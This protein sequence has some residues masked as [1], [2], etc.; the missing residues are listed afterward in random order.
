MTSIR[1]AMRSPMLCVT[2]L[3]SRNALVDSEWIGTSAGLLE[4]C[5]AATGCLDNQ[6]KR[7]KRYASI[8]I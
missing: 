4:C 6:I 8:F 3:R 5:S 7:E 1:D 2:V